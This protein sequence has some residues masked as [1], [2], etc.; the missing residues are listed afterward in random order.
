MGT[1]N[2]KPPSIFD[3]TYSEEPVPKPAQAV[4]PKDIPMTLSQTYCTHFGSG[5]V[6]QSWSGIKGQHATVSEIGHLKT[7]TVSDRPSHTRTDTI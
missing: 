6:V 3:R 7:Q 1:C 5:V 4:S 2:A